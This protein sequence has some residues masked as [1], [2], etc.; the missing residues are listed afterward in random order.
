MATGAGFTEAKSG[1]DRFPVGNRLVIPRNWRPFIDSLPLKLRLNGA[2]KQD[3]M[4]GDMLLKLDEIVEQALSESSEER[5]RF[6]GEPVS[7]VEDGRIRAGQVVLT[8]T[9]GGVLMQLPTV[10]HLLKEC[11]VWLFTAAWLDQSLQS[12]L[13]DRFVADS[14]AADFFLQQGDEIEMS[15]GPLGEIRIKITVD[16]QLD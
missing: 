1:V 11:L 6:E 4:G 10:G 2:L 13:V 5:W 12:W 8:G 15:A 14:E 7:L 16:D 3:A 9:P